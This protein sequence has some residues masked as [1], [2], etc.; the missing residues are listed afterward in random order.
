MSA[1]R[2]SLSLAGIALFVACALVLIFGAAAAVFG[3]QSL[4]W[5]TNLGG[6]LFAALILVEMLRWVVIWLER[7]GREG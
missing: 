2:F 3:G 7:R 1:L 4:S 6:W 5:A